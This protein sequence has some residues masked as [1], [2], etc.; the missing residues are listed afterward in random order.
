[1]KSDV[2]SLPLSRRSADAAAPPGAGAEEAPAPEAQDLASKVWHLE[3]VLD[4]LAD[5]LF[6]LE[7]AIRAAGT[8]VNQWRL[9]GTDDSGAWDSATRL[10]EHFAM[11]AAT[12]GKRAMEA[13]TR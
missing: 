4:H 9:N 13:E 8:Q 1:M 3:L 5:D 11:S 7:A 12:L 2:Y 6:N 10:F